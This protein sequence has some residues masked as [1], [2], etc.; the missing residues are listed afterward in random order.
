MS[1]R[2]FQEVKPQEIIVE[3]SGVS[4]RLCLANC[5]EF[6]MDAAD[7]AEIYNKLTG[8]QIKEKYIP[9]KICSDCV[10]KLNQFMEFYNQCAE[11]EM[12]MLKLTLDLQEDTEQQEQEQ[13]LDDGSEVIIEE[14]VQ[15]NGGLIMEPPN[16]DQQHCF[17]LVQSDEEVA[18][19]DSSNQQIIHVR[20]KRKFIEDDSIIYDESMLGMNDDIVLEEIT[21]EPEPAPAPVLRPP[22][23]RRQPPTTVKTTPPAKPDARRS[24][25]MPAQSFPQ[26]KPKAPEPPTP[27][28]KFVCEICAKVKH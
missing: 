13:V 12:A 7:F 24:R 11:V 2:N 9:R 10:N 18:G 26:L 21:V 28:P 17:E 5:T 8:F 19:I 27:E 14:F 15:P 16:D 20:K 25:V 1:Y 4:C 3:I 6:D 22:Q 23:I